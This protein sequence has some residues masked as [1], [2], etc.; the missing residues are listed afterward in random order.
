MLGCDEF[1]A[2]ILSASGGAYSTL[3]DLSLS[4]QEKVAL[5]KFQTSFFEPYID[6]KIEIM[7]NDSSANIRF[8]YDIKSKKG[9]NFVFEV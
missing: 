4:A 2:E 3:D 1:R 8:E 6:V 5:S 7:Q 9:S